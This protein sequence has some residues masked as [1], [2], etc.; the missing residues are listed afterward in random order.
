MGDATEGNR[1][2]LNQN[3]KKKKTPKQT[4]RK[5]LQQAESHPINQNSTDLNYFPAV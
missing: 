3:V 5:T 2:K 1:L 4:Q